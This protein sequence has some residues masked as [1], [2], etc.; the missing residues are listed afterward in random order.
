[1][2]THA[3]GAVLL[4]PETA[5]STTVSQS[6]ASSPPKAKRQP[7]FKGA[8]SSNI[9]GSSGTYGLWADAYRELAEELGIKPRVLQSV[10][11]VAKRK[12]FDDRMTKETGE[13]GAAHM[14]RIPRREAQ[15]GKHPERGSAAGWRHGQAGGRVA[16]AEGAEAAQGQGSAQAEGCQE[17]SGRRSCF[18]GLNGLHGVHL[19]AS[20]ADPFGV[21]CDF[22][23]SH[24]A[25]LH[26]D[27]TLTSWQRRQHVR[28]A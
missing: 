8:S 27:A 22:Y 5:N 12:L 25:S 1:M 14:A 15:P 24:P 19:T 20:V 9:T 7:G 17:G 23:R 4:R 10:T 28:S 21:R 3:V 16:P 6:L 2:D 13:V 18:H 26:Q 11:W